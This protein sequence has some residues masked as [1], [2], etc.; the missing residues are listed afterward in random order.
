MLPQ[1]KSVTAREDFTL[2]IL[3][4]DGR[5]KIFN[6]MPYL[7][8]GVFKKLKDWNLFRQARVGLGTVVWPED[9]DIAPETLYLEGIHI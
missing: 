1:V 3:F 9:L 7:N 6:A 8:R 4:S 5:Q 2:L